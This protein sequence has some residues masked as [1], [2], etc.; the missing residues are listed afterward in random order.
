MYCVCI[1]VFKSPRKRKY[2]NREQRMKMDRQEWNT[3]KLDRKH[4]QLGLGGKH[5]KQELHLEHCGVS[6]K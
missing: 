2:K 5:K 1:S 6:T 3:V 4:R